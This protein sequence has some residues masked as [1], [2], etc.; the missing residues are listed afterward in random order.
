MQGA[1][2]LCIVFEYYSTG[3]HCE[4]AC[5]KTHEGKAGKAKPK[6]KA[7]GESKAKGGKSRLSVVVADAGVLNSSACGASIPANVG[8]PLVGSDDRANMVDGYRL[9]L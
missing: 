8:C 9:P 1:G 3:H 7:K 2:L 6:E 5:I 4:A